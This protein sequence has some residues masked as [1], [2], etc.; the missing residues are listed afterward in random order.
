M[1][2][3]HSEIVPNGY[4]F[5][6]LRQELFNVFIHSNISFYPGVSKINQKFK[7]SKKWLSFDACFE[8]PILITQ[9][10]FY[11]NMGK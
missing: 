1:Y 9:I 11:P 8:E 3:A 10:N 6:N 7:V 2:N 5:K 4:T